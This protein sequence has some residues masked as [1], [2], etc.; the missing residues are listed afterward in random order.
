MKTLRMLALVPVM[1]LTQC[2][3]LQDGTK[4]FD[5]VKAQL[6]INIAVPHAVEYGIYKEPKARKYLSTVAVLID[7]FAT[8]TDLQPRELEL[9]LDS[10]DVDLLKTKEARAVVDTVIALYTAYYLDVVEAKLD[11]HHLVDVLKTLSTA[12]RKGL[13]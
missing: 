13:N 9:V 1:V 2:I 3:T 7:V 5:P 4:T 6:V 12:I 10:S 11:Q 8:G